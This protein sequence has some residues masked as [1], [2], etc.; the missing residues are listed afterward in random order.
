[1]RHPGARV[2]ANGSAGGL[3]PDFFR[4]TRPHRRAKGTARRARVAMVLWFYSELDDPAA[5]AAALRRELPDLELDTSPSPR[6]P[7]AVRWALVYRPPSGALA[8]L[9]NLEAIFSL[10]AG[11]ESLLADPTLPDVP[12]C[13]MVDPGLT[14][15]IADYAHL[16]VLRAH[17]GFDRFERAQAEGRWTFATPKPASEVTVAVLGLGELGAAVAGRLGGQGYRVEGWS[18]G[19]RTVAGV[20]GRHGPDGLASAVADADVV[21]ALLPATPATRDLFD[22][23]FFAAM[24]PGATFVNL[25]RGDQLVEADLLEALDTGGL[26][27]AVLDVFRTEPLPPDHPFWRHPRVLVTPHVGGSTLPA[28]GAPVVADNIRRARAG[29]PLRHLVDRARGY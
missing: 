22:A 12:L 18:R 26:G 15:T 1:M 6:D 4:S 24:K 16:A 23:A 7:A 19:P 8:A 17:R 28:T 27:G 3:H 14:A 9:P 11:V 5:W 10:G 2:A 20:T 25:G 29:R 13:R 21:V